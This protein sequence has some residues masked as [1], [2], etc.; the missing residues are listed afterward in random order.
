MKR[1]VLL[2]IIVLAAC[3]SYA[4]KRTEVARCSDVNTQAQL[5][6]LCLVTEHRWKEP[7]ADSAGRA[8]ERELDSLRALREDSVWTLDAQRHRRELRECMA[9]LGEVRDCLLGYGWP[10]ARAR[11]ASDSA[12]RADSAAHRRQ[13]GDCL[14]RERTANISA[15][16]QLYYKWTPERALATND[17]VRRA[18]LR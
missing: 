1:L 16:L 15:C 13:I 10:E 5:I 14:R 3:K 11:R 2:L 9:M 8:R 12:W 4:R 17:S 18:Q 6:A 7:A